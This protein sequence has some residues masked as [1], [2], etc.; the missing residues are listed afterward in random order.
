MRAECAMVCVLQDAVRSGL[1]KFSAVSEHY[2]INPCASWGPRTPHG[3]HRVP[4]SGPTISGVLILPSPRAL[5]SPKVL[6]G[7]GHCQT[8][9]RSSQH[10]HCG[11]ILLGCVSRSALITQ[12]VQ[13]ARNLLFNGHT[14]A[15]FSSPSS[16]PLWRFLGGG[17]GGGNKAW[18]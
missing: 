18:F 2:V 5:F 7:F 12:G 16:K 17:G 14:P 4:S 3:Q 9:A 15:L 10:L 11:L 1:E 8:L 13:I 6:R